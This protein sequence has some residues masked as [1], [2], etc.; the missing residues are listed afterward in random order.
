MRPRSPS[1]DGFSLT[2]GAFAGTCVTLTLLYGLPELGVDAP[3]WWVPAMPAAALG[4]AAAE[5]V[6]DALDRAAVR[7]WYLLAPALG[8]VPLA[9]ISLAGAV[10]TPPAAVES[11]RLPALALAFVGVLVAGAGSARRT[12]VVAERETVHARA[13]LSEPIHSRLFGWVVTVPL[14]VVALEFV[15]TGRVGLRNVVWSLGGIGVAALVVGFFDGPKRVELRA[16][17]S[18]LVVSEVGTTGGDLVPWT[19]IR[20]VETDG[21]EVRL[22]RGLPRPARYRGDLPAPTEAKAFADEVRRRRRS[23]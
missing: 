22:H 13:A 21:A 11:L 2:L 12:D 16:L 18:G 23:S 1:L 7:R 8:V 15:L 9:V 6:P 5:Q 19:R 4:W 20:S 17:D 3:P 10:W 14:T